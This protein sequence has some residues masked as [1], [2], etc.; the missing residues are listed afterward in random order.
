MGSGGGG[1]TGVTSYPP[2]M[3]AFH[4][5]ILDNNGQDFGML[6]QSALAS[7]F[8]ATEGFSPFYSYRDPTTG[9]DLD[10]GFMGGSKSLNSYAKV[11][12]LLKLWQDYNFKQEYEDFTTVTPDI[13]TLADVSTIADIDPTGTLDAMTPI[14]P[15]EFLVDLSMSLDDDIELN[16]LP[17]FLGEMRSIGAVMSSAFVVGQAL[18]QDSKLKALAKERVNI[19]QLA[20]SSHDVNTK[21]RTVQGGFKI[22]VGKI[23]T[24]NEIEVAKIN[25]LNKLQVLEANRLNRAQAMQLALAYGELKKTIALS[26]ADTIKVY[27]SLTGDFNKHYADMKAAD[28]KWDLEMLQYINN[29]LASISGAALSNGNTIPGGGIGSAVGGMLSGAATGAMATGGNPIGVGA[30]A[31]LGLAGGLFK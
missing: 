17:K 4:G 21:R 23:N 11:F 16:V 31:V 25:N 22:E 29:T 30:G 12:D 19:E 20:L 9:N 5:L 24:G 6:P 1:S 10:S 15:D 3:T 26:T 8:N 27:C 18:I 2:Y 7:Y 28:T 13:A 14:D